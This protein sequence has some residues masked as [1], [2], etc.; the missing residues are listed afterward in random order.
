MSRLA[1][2]LV[3]LLVT[4]I[5]SPFT[6]PLSSCG[7]ADLLAHRSTGPMP[8]ADDEPSPVLTNVAVHVLVAD[9]SRRVKDDSDWRAALPPVVSTGVHA[10]AAAALP[11]H[12]VLVPP[13]RTLVLRI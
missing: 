9:E 2:G 6:A 11:Q 5:V 8:K 7:L 3:V 13:G 1:R 4:L 10:A 12:Q